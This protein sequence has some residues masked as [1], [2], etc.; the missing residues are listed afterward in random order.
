MLCRFCHSFKGI[1]NASFCFFARLAWLS[2]VFHIYY[3]F[4]YKYGRL[5]KNGRNTLEIVWN[6]TNVIYRTV[7]TPEYASFHIELIDEKTRVK[8]AIFTPPTPFEKVQKNIY[9]LL[10]HLWAAM[11]LYLPPLNLLNSSHTSLPQKREGVSAIITQ[12][13][14]VE[15]TKNCATNFK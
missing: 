13:Y 8:G 6:I 14:E 5:S 11:L 10:E 1:R 3:V 15:N 9:N 12:I 4:I 2:F 7:I